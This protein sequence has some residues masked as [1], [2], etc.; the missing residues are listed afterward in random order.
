MKNEGIISAS[1]EPEN[2]PKMANNRKESIKKNAWKVVL[3]SGIFFIL[4]LFFMGLGQDPRRIPSPLINKM[5]SPIEAPALDGGPPIS[6]TALRGK[7]VIINFWGS[8]CTACIAEHPLLIDLAQ[9]IK[10]RND[11]VILGVD[12]KD[13]IEGAKGF[14][15]RLGDP[16][17]RH[18]LD[19]NQKIAIDWGVYGAPETYLV[20]PKG[21]IRFKQI[22]PI[23]PEWYEERVLPL[24]ESEF[25]SVDPS[26]QR[27]STNSFPMREKP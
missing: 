10:Q 25:I 8:W 23:Y 3:L 24:L 14:L 19:P 7:W 6:L 20:D 27:F 9:K 16:G 2:L 15:K 22:G 21:M 17:Y 12:F 18:A 26:N 11:V 1:L 13:T 5:A 4:Y